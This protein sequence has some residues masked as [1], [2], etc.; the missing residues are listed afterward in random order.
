MPPPRVSRCLSIMNIHG[1]RRAGCR[2]HKACMGWSCAVRGHIAYLPAQLVLMYLLIENY[3]YILQ[4]VICF[5]WCTV[6]D[7][8]LCSLLYVTGSDFCC[9][10]CETNLWNESYFNGWLS[11]LMACWCA[12]SGLSLLVWQ[13]RGYAARKKLG[14]WCTD[15]DLTGAKNQLLPPPPPSSH[16]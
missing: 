3:D 8:L 13:Q 10:N 4:P 11:C 16:L 6:K 2:R 12:F 5:W 15:G 9:R 7:Q 1:A 14:C